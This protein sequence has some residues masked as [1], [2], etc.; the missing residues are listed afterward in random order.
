MTDKIKQRIERKIEETKKV[1]AD[2][3]E[4]RNKYYEQGNLN[5]YH[6]YEGVVDE[7]QATLSLLQ[8]LIEE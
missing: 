8:S 6:Y 5:N 3:K 4:F 7:L 1:L 2:C